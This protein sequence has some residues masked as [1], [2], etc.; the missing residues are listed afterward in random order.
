MRKIE[1]GNPEEA[2]AV[3]STQGIVSTIQTVNIITVEP[4]DLLDALD[5]LADEFQLAELINLAKA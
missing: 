1:V 5:I 4:V 3:L 2:Q